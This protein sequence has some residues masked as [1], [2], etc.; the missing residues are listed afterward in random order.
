M[1]IKIKELLQ[2]KKVRIGLYGLAIFLVVLA[3]VTFILNFN[4]ITKLERVK[5]EEKSD[6]ITAYLSEITENKDDNGRYINFAIEYLYNNT[7]KDVYSVDEVKNVINSIFNLEYTDE[8][9]S[10][11]GISQAMQGKGIVF[12]N[13]KGTYK[14]SNTRTIT[15]IANDN[16][17]Y[18]KIDKIKKINKNKFKVV[19]KKYVIDEPYEILNYYNNYNIEH[20]D[21]KEEQFDTSKIVNYLK[22][23][24][25]IGAVKQ[26]INEEDNKIFG[27]EDGKTSVT[28]VIKNKKLLIEKIS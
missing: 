5:L 21:N 7:D 26:I 17:Y 3:L 11:I 20:Y 2:N 4:K 23:K 19:Y 6:E 14:Y 16:I 13:S 10:E 24:E 1:M 25:K 28:Y 9:I 12:D 27:T 15:D 18:F 22:G 8:T